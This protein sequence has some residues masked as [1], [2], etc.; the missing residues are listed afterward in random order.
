MAQITGTEGDDELNGTD[1]EDTIFGL[2]GNDLIH[3]SAADDEIDGGTGD[4][5]FSYV[6]VY[7]LRGDTI[8]GGDGADTLRLSGAMSAGVQFAANSLTG[9][10]TIHL[11]S[12]GATGYNRYNIT[13][14]NGN[15]AAG[16][17]L[18]VEGGTLRY[19]ENVFFYGQGEA[20]GR[21]DITT[22]GG[23]DYLYG[24]R[25][26]DIV[27]AGA[28]RDT[29]G[30]G[31]GDDY[32]DGG[33]GNDTMT[34]GVG[35]DYYVVDSAA[36]VVV[37]RSGEGTDEILVRVFTYTLPEHVERASAAGI[38]TANAQDN[39]ITSRS[40]LTVH[41]GQ[42]GAD[43]I[44][45]GWSTDA[46]YFGAAFGAGDSFDGGGGGNDRMHL[47]GDYSAGVAIGNG[48]VTSVETLVLGSG[49]ESGGFG[50]NLT[51]DDTVLTVGA[52]QVNASA[53]RAGETLRFD[54]AAEVGGTFNI[55]SGAG[56]DW[57]S[58]GGAGD[59]LRG[60]L[61]GDTMSGN[62]GNDRFLA[63][64]IDELTG[65]RID[66]GAGLDTLELNGRFSS[67]FTFLADTMQGVE[68]ILLA[69]GRLGYSTAY[70]GYNLTM[71]D[72]NVAAGELLTVNGSALY[73][74]EALMFYGAAETDGRFAITGGRSGDYLHGGAGDDWM[75]GGLGRDYLRGNGGADTFAYGS[76]AEATSTG[77]DQL[78][79]F[80]WRE[81][82]IDLPGEVSGW[83]GGAAGTLSAAT[84]DA[85]LAAAVNG[86]L[87]AGGALL[88]T[89]DGGDYS[90]RSFIVVDG[91]GDGAYTANQDYVLELVSPAAPLPGTT[92][93]FI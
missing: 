72:A 42:G 23:T 19:G 30:G 43:T 59:S 34:G 55:H 74:G 90:G 11:V 67:G 28:G 20:D 79:G 76:A 81:D 92:D 47:D 21:F 29:L 93:F 61:G 14:N 63:F 91:N 27:R 39:V 78:V 48:M 46:V 88:F 13:M 60:G 44:I 68:T 38:L 33:I 71:N 65:D 82:R 3:G 73:V 83:N 5:V 80:D 22:G 77:F 26:N 57:L 85:D 50:Y 49:G 62:G 64:S 66:G 1:G 32:L 53:L 52:L 25:G 37:E 87:A 15:V 16:Q 84:F 18:R 12:S 8:A 10:E 41:A 69:T 86:A 17:T 54:G 51:L 31:A 70:H 45:G 75:K 40:A 58:T 4:D 24:G 56:D 36:D 9:V 2:G 6:D 35:N 89:A 7:H